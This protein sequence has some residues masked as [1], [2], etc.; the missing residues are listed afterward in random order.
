MEVQT[1]PP[2]PSVLS[3]PAPAQTPSAKPSPTPPV[4]PAHAGQ[5]AQPAPAGSSCLRSPCL[6]RHRHGPSRRRHHPQRRLYPPRRRSRRCVEA[7]ASTRSLL[8]DAGIHHTV[9]TPDDCRTA[10]VRVEG[11]TRPQQRAHGIDG[12]FNLCTP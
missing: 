6:Q 10:A 3:A 9:P 12:Q 11:V 7:Y 4:A 2:A 1:E 5:A 8:A